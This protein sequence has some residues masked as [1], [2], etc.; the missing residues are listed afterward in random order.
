MSACLYTRLPA[1]PPARLPLG[2]AKYLFVDVNRAFAS[3]PIRA[4][5]FQSQSR[6]IRVTSY[7]RPSTRLS[8]NY[9]SAQTCSRPTSQL[10]NQP[11]DYTVDTQG[12][13]PGGGM[14]GGWP[15]STPRS[16]PLSTIVANQPV[17]NAP[18]RSRKH[19][20]KDCRLWE[21]DVNDPWEEVGKISG[22]VD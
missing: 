6:L 21:K 20:S 11:S 9:A 7:V 2:F 1:V 3:L 18:Y 8:R 19:L 13:R 22:G 17:A 15:D 5:P 14:G 10:T 12:V 4:I 16:W